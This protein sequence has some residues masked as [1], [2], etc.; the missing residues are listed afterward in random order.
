M[1]NIIFPCTIVWILFSGCQSA[2]PEKAKNAET[3][4]KV[5]FVL[6]AV[7]ATGPSSM[8]KLPGQLAAYQEVSIFPKVIGYVKNVNVDIGSKV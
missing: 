1:K 6:A 2:K 7:Q 5:N 3:D 8:I 4:K